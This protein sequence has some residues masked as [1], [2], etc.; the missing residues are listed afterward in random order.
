VTISIGAGCLR[1]G[2]EIADLYRCADEMLYQAKRT[3]R[4]KVCH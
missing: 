2:M 3:G 4:N 1:D